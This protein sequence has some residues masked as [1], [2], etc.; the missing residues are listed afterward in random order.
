MKPERCIFRLKPGSSAETSRNPASVADPFGSS[1]ALIK[2]AS[3]IGKYWPV[4]PRINRLRHPR[5]RLFLFGNK[6]AKIS[7]RPGTLGIKLFSGNT[8]VEQ[9]A[10]PKGHCNGYVSRVASTR[11]QNTANASTVMSGIQRV[12]AS[13]QI[14]L[15]HG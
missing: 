2:S 11:N 3:S 1:I 5:K 13:A 4:R 6:F 12:P 8:E 14:S 15:E 7:Q 9:A 10:F